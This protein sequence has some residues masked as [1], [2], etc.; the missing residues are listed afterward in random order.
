MG[1]KI[2]LHIHTVACGHG[3]STFSEIVKEASDKKM[4]VIAITE[5]GPAHDPRGTTLDFFNTY[6]V[7]PNEFNDVR[8]LKGCEVNIIANSGAVDLPEELLKKMDIIIASF[9]TNCKEKDTIEKN[10]QAYVNAMGNPYVDIIGHPDDINNYPYDPEILAKAAVENDVALEV[11][12][13]S[14]LARPGSEKLCI[15]MLKA[16]K[17]Y[18]TK[19]SIGSDSHYHTSIGNFDH[20]MKLIED[21]KIDKDKII[22]LSQERLFKH[23]R[24]NHIKANWS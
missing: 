18:G 19:L 20:A 3:Y 16:A 12:S 14:N 8:I 11:N 10:T 1:I 24:R 4:E 5:H 7:L 6:R 17:K 13:S 2:D 9:H 21:L 23:L 15:E 22:N